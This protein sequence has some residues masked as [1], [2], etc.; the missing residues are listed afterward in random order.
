MTR[1]KSSLL[2]ISVLALV[3]ACGT[4]PPSDYYLLAARSG[5]PPTGQTPSLGVGPVSVPEYLNRNSMVYNRSGTKL[6]VATYA[7]W[8]EPLE[9]GISRVL[10]LNLAINLNTEDI[11]DFPWHTSRAPDYS[12]AVRVLE[13]DANSTRARLVAEWSLRRNSGENG[14]LRRI[15]QLELATGGSELSPDDVAQ[16]YSTLLGELSD[17]I[18][19]AIKDSMSAGEAP[20]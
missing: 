6:D 15:S 18:A 5:S 7:R 12:V 19:T 10:S 17:R 4:T 11:Q 14:T 2:L 3:S 1:V 9:A 13:L 20:G 8:A 16:A